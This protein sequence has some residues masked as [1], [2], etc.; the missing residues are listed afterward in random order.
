VS[1][2]DISR[3]DKIRAVFFDVGNTLIHAFP[4]VGEI[5]SKIAL[6]YGMILDGDAVNTSFKRSFLHNS[7]SP[8]IEKSGE[9]E[10]WKRIVWETITPLCRPKRYDDFFHELFDFFTKDAAWK[11][12]P[13]VIP[14]LDRLKAMGIIMGVISNWDSRLLPTLDNLNLSPYFSVVAVSAIVGSA[15][16]DPGIFKYAL[17][18]T[19]V[20]PEEAIHIGDTIEFDLEGARGYGIQALLLD[21]SN[22]FP[23][24]PKHPTV[25][26]LDRIF[27]FLT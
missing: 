12:F 24:N 26:S 7:V 8:L 19:H 23:A 6:K 13:D 11:V 25:P 20:S 5:Y 10:W 15:K 17:E 27:T 16:P 14:T 2:K 18:K 21:R 22:S 4:S 1:F 3:L 9:V